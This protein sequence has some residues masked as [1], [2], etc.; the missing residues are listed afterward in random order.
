MKFLQ[1]KSYYTCFEEILYFYFIFNIFKIVNSIK[2]LNYQVNCCKAAM[3]RKI[4]KEE[5]LKKNILGVRIDFGQKRVYYILNI[6][7]RKN[8]LKNYKNIL[9]V[10]CLKNFFI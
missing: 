7:E 4:K 9:Q 10:K 8:T 3:E 1:R 2:H 6:K 5:K